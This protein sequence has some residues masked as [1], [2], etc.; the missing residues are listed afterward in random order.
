MATL[1]CEIQAHCI[2]GS[3]LNLKL[4]SCRAPEPSQSFGQHRRAVSAT[5]VPFA[6]LELYIVASVAQSSVHLLVRQWPA[7]MLIVPVPC[8]K[9]KPTSS[10][11]D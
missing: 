2:G 8:M 6:P 10:K 9:V 7:A 5:V 3:Q 1:S 4:R 11:Q